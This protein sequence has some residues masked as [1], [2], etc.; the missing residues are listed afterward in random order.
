[1]P[2]PRVLVV[3]D[4]E[5]IRRLVAQALRQHGFE[6]LLADNGPEALRMAVDARPAVAVVDQW[7]P[8][9]TGAELIRLLRAAPLPELRA[10]PIVGLSGKGGS[11]DEL[12]AAGAG[13]FVSKPFG[14]LDLVGAV[15]AA[16]DLAAAA[17]GAA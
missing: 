4:A 6:V 2:S 16:L 12:L 3:D 5:A 8:G 7:M 10:M 14:E 13:S 17:S 11:E 1:M 9:M 15:R